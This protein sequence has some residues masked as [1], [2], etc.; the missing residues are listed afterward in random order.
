MDLY[1][2]AGWWERGLRHHAPPIVAQQGV[3][4]MADDKG[5]ATCCDW[6]T[7]PAE[8][9]A[10]AFFHARDDAARRD[11]AL[12]LATWC[13]DNEAPF[14]YFGQLTTE[15]DWVASAYS[16]TS[17]S[18]R[19]ERY[20]LARR[21]AAW[22]CSNGASIRF[23]ETWLDEGAWLAMAYRTCDDSASARELALRLADLCL[24][25][26]TS[27]LVD[28]SWLNAGDW[29]ARAYARAQGDDAARIAGRVAA[30]CRENDCS[31]QLEGAWHDAAW[32]ERASRGSATAR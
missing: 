6:S 13:H 32:W 9:L 15:G 22:C 31:V 25:G 1:G 3:R 11:A 19:A 8:E 23:R 18:D 20:R 14:S 12:E 7:M 29:L 26:H 30:W 21:A 10:A 28:G 5:S 2:R 16:Y 24:G 27:Y 17:A 4:R